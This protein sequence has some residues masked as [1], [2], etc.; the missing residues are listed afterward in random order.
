MKNKMSMYISDD[1]IYLSLGHFRKDKIILKKLEKLENYISN[2]EELKEYINKNYKLR[3]FTKVNVI[4]ENKY[5][6]LEENAD[7]SDEEFEEF[8]N[9]KYGNEFKVQTIEF[10]RSKVDKKIKV[11]IRRELVE[12]YRNISSKIGA[13][14]NILLPVF[15]KVASYFIDKISGNLILIYISEE[16]MEISFF[17]D[18][19]FIYFK[20]YAKVDIERAVELIK[21]FIREIFKSTTVETLIYGNYYLDRY[22]SLFEEKEVKLKKLIESNYISKLKIESKNIDKLK[23]DQNYINSILSLY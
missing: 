23:E 6:L 7:Y 4:L 21:Y 1:N 14:P 10:N 13:Q 17:E 5:F 12:K 22:K 3:F 11:S 8:L 9:D 16:I 19:T 18:Y 20:Q 2:L 15:F